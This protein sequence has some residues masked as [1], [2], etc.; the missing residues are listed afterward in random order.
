M[1]RDAY[2]Y[3]RDNRIILV[4][5][6]RLSNCYYWADPKT[7]EPKGSTDRAYILFNDLD[8]AIET[9]LRKGYAVTTE[10]LRNIP[11]FALLLCLLASSCTGIEAGG[12]LWITRVDQRQESQQTHNVPLK[13][14]L[15]ANC[16]QPTTETQG[17]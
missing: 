1:I 11:K 4:K 2:D 5:E 15:W 10:I 8:D 17:S 14:Y 12:K 7:G 3:R 6:N 13:C 9:A 16:G